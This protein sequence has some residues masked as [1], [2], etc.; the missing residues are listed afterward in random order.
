MPQD[1]RTEKMSGCLDSARQMAA[2]PQLKLEGSWRSARRRAAA[3]I[4]IV[5]QTSLSRCFKMRA[6]SAPM[7]GAVP[8]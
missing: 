2:L 5:T 6:R 8:A 3:D 1:A 7:S 4:T